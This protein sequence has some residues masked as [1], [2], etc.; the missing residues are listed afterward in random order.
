MGESDNFRSAFASKRRARA[1]NLCRGEREK[2]TRE[3]QGASEFEYPVNQGKNKKVQFKRIMS[4]TSGSSSE[5]TTTI[6]SGR[7]TSVKV[8]N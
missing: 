3:R 8:C 6:V 4:Q 7:N 1:L 2:G 5:Q